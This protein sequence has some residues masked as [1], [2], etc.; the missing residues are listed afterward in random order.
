MCELV[1]VINLEVIAIYANVSIMLSLACCQEKSAE[2]VVSMQQ[3]VYTGKPVSV[4]D[5]PSDYKA[6]QLSLIH[7]FFY[8]SDV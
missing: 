2:A 6:I 5:M 3:L 4:Y 1:L 8:V 7:H